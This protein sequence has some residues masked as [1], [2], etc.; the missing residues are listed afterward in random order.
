M[1]YCKIKACWKITFAFLSL[2]ILIPV[3]AMPPIP[4][5]YDAYYSVF[6]SV[7]NDGVSA[8]RYPEGESSKGWSERLVVR[9]LGEMD[10]RP[11]S[12]WMKQ[13][14]AEFA[15]GCESF[16]SVDLLEGRSHPENES[17]FFWVCFG[18]T[19]TQYG[20]LELAKVLHSH[21][22]VYLMVVGGRVPKYQENKI[23][24]VNPE[25]EKRWFSSLSAFAACI[26]F[27]QMQCLPGE[28]LFGQTPVI[29][30]TPE[31]KA[32]VALAVSRGKALY[33]QDYLAWHG[34]DF[35][36][37]KK[38]LPKNGKGLG[39]I[40][41]PTAARAGTFYLLSAGKNDQVQAD[42]FI[43]DESGEFTV[44]PHLDSLPESLAIRLKV[45]KIAREAKFTMC[46]PAL[47]TVVLQHENGRDWLVYIMSAT[48]KFEEVWIGGHTRI[49]VSEDGSKVLSITPSTKACIAFD[50]KALRASGKNAANPLTQI[51]T[52]VPTEYHVMQSLAHAVP[53]TIVTETGVWRVT[54]D[55]IDKH[56]VDVKKKVH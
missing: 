16:N 27:T 24:K 28:A 22:E 14:Q 52:N 8:N 31:E 23:P 49:H 1:K 19:G 48:Q 39:F 7:G 38:M 55:K 34:S 25:Y 6:E 41:I 40:A 44:G 21:G 35:A 12:D 37:A 33:N 4:G 36:V 17:V 20:R 47:N 18:E 13:A 9:R 56:S 15:K 51:L 32:E 3:Y 54:G 45:L 26:K 30:A 46:S 10:K 2:S 53:L 50:A 5:T 43:A 29:A 42:T 11:L